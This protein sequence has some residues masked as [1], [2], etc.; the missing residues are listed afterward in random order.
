MRLPEKAFG[1]VC[2]NVRREIKFVKTEKSSFSLSGCLDIVALDISLVRRD[3]TREG[4]C[5]ILCEIDL[6]AWKVLY[7]ERLRIV[8]S[9]LLPSI[10]E[11]FC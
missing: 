3:A 2:F 5:Y 1:N 8:R 9:Q 7:A 10:A 11:K 6:A 4:F